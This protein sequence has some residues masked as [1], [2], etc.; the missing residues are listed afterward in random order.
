MMKYIGDILKPSKVTFL[1]A[2]FSCKLTTLYLLNADNQHTLYIQNFIFQFIRLL[3]YLVPNKFLNSR[4]E[5]KC[6]K[7]RPR[8]RLREA[9]IRTTKPS[10]FKINAK[11]DEKYGV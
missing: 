4:E 1:Y 10:G 7:Y 3:I 2:K 5:L 11:N 8:Q 6:T 9:K